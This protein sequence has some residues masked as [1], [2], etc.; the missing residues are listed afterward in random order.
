MINVYCIA[1]TQ[2]ENVQKPKEEPDSLKPKINALRKNFEMVGIKYYNLLFVRMPC[3]MQS[4]W[5]RLHDR[6][7]FR[8]FT[9]TVGKC[10]FSFST[11]CIDYI[12]RSNQSIFNIVCS[13]PLNPIIFEVNS[14][15]C[16]R[17]MRYF[18]AI[19]LYTNIF[20]TNIIFLNCL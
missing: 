7:G 6:K 12:L 3:C 10:H 19:G 1:C 20:S 8:D 16:I 13:N 4:C 18:I 11:I 17:I 14:L 2:E 5:C 15:S 9:A